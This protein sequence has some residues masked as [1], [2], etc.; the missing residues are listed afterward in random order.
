MK[1]IIL[2]FLLLF[3]S[4]GIVRAA[5]VAS[6]VTEVKQPSNYTTP[7]GYEP[8]WYIGSIISQIFDPV[9]QILSDYVLAFQNIINTDNTVPVWNS[10]TKV[11]E[12]GTITDT[13]TNIGIWESNPWEKLSV[14]GRL[15]IT[16]NPNSDD[17][18]WDR[19]YNDGRYVNVWESINGDTIQ[20]G[21]IDSS[22]I[23]NGSIWE[24]DL[25]QNQIDDSEIQNNS[26]T[27]SSLAANSVG[28]S[29]LNNSES[30]S[31]AWLTLYSDATIN[32]M[33]FGRGG[34]NS[35]SNTA[36]WPYVLTGNSWTYNTAIWYA[37]LRNNST[38]RFNLWI[39]P[40]TL[41]TNTT[42][43]YNIWLGYNALRRLSSNGTN[44][45][46]GTNALEDTTS[47]AGVAVWH[48]AL[49]GVTTWAWNTWVWSSV[50]RGLR[51]WQF[52]T[53][54][55]YEAGRNI[56]TGSRNVAIWYATQVPSATASDQLNIAN[57]IYWVS[58][59][60]IGIGTSGPTQRLDVNGKIRMRNQ[61]SNSDSNDTV[62]TKGYVDNKV[63][64]SSSIEVWWI[65]FE[66]RRA[67]LCYWNWSWT[68]NERHWVISPDTCWRTVE[69]VTN[70]L[71]ECGFSG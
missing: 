5:S 13:G 17:D 34:G 48:L 53:S 14:N 6:N 11:F 12:V 59:G 70:F 37:S 15:S 29:E 23:Q 25:A 55:W 67:E 1:K 27:A 36:I 41:T 20:D 57:K 40:N 18:V 44:I 52:N 54:I 65:C 43:S 26:L 8:K 4:V 49:D 39:W 2:I 45:A 50:M 33:T 66:P 69:A 56:S 16:W 3:L 21:T 64:S 35:F 46:I 22:E 63:S 10:S 7:S 24:V 60:N 47:Y 28:N 61:T 30:F 32:G 62:A 58:N 38:W 42:W 19:L 71:V 68:W 9:W 51:T 31:M